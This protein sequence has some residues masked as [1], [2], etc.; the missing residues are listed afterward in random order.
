MNCCKSRPTA[1]WFRQRWSPWL[2]A[3]AVLLGANTSQASRIVMV[4]DFT[5][6][7]LDSAWGTPV[8]VL[9]NASP[10]QPNFSVTANADKLTFTHTNTANTASQVAMLRD[11]FSLVNDGDYVQVTVNLQSITGGL[12]AILGGLVLDSG[13]T[14]PGDRSNNYTM[15]MVGNGRIDVVRGGTIIGQTATGLFAAGE[16]VL[17]RFTR[18]SPTSVL[19]S[20][21]LDDG[22]TFINV[23]GITA[24]ERN[25]GGFLAAGVYTGNNTLATT[26][27]TWVFDDFVYFNAIPEPS[28]WALVALGGLGLAVRRRSARKS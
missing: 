2:A 19:S 28:T 24:S 17:L 21:S 10:A 22:A 20:Y 27:T 16:E 13:S 7:T 26:G 15:Y 5:T 8:N 18:L 14:I 12:T 9:A 11:D 23:T 6:D 1:S 25:L 3:V 4:D